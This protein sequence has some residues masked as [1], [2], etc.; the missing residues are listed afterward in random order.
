MGFGLRLDVIA[1]FDC[2]KVA[3]ALSVLHD[4]TLW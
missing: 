3:Q 2:G 1:S 4:A